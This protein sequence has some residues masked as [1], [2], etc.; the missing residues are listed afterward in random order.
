MAMA[1][2]APEQGVKI[3]LAGVKLYFDGTVDRSLHDHLFPPAPPSPSIAS[4]GA[5]SKDVP[6]DSTTGVWCRIFLP[7]SALSSV[8]DGEVSRLPIVL[9]FHGGAFVLYSAASVFYHDECCK[10]AAR[11]GAIVISVNYRLAPEHKLPAAFDDGFLALKWLQAQGNDLGVADPWLS[12]HADFS[13]C[14]LMGHSSGATLLHHAV[15]TAAAAGSSYLQI[16]RGLILGIP[17]F[18][19]IERTSSEIKYPY[20]H[21]IVTASDACW[22]ISL[23]DGA[24]RSH[25]YC[26]FLSSQ[27]P[28]LLQTIQWPPSL[29]VVGALDP[30]YDR[31]IQY[32]QHIRKAGHEVTLK[33]Y[34]Y[35]GHG[36]RFPEVTRPEDVDEAYMIMQEFL[37]KCF[38]KFRVVPVT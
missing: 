10:L 6:I 31:Q 2:V 36:I 35:Y 7:E 17:F 4:S 16:I 27:N 37:T 26:S 14:I 24:D 12:S 30:L 25:P 18:G 8:S 23:P 22:A 28:D 11:I 13:K 33:K 38:R 15:L 3:E 21:E 29:V 9:Y 5:F 34:A 32:V 19:G 20:S 1:S